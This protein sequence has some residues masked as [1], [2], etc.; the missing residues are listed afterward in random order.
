MVEYNHDVVSFN[1]DTTIKASHGVIV[2]VYVTKTGS[3]GSKVVFK[4]GG[5][6]GTTE[7]SIFAEQQGTYVGINRRFED[8]IYADITGDAEYTVVYK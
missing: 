5:S 1:S 2:S 4:N 6:S 8:G 7:F 3:S